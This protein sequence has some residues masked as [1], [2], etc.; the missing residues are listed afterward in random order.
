MWCT[1]ISPVLWVTPQRIIRGHR[2][3]GTI[4]PKQNCDNTQSSSKYKCTICRGCENKRWALKGQLKWRIHELRSGDCKT[5]G[6]RGALHNELSTVLLH[7]P[8]FIK[9]DETWTSRTVNTW[10]FSDETAERWR[11]ATSLVMK[12]GQNYHLRW[13]QR[14]VRPHIRGHVPLGMS[15]EA[16]SWLN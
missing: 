2:Y 4:V 14:S 9:T 8:P 7:R 6:G 12:A 11:P 13:M 16:L 10:M 1:L 5:E 15:R 3:E